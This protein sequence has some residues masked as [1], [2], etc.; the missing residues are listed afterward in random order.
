MSY[1]LSSQVRPIILCGGGGTRLWPLSRADMPKQFLP[2]VGEDSLLQA[3]AKRCQGGPFLPPAL[4]V[5]EEHGFMVVEQLEA[6]GV[7]SASILLEPA[8]RNT[9]PAVALAALWSLQLKDE[10]ILV[11]PSDHVID[12]V[13][14]LH[15]AVGAATPAALAGAIVTFGIKPTAPNPGYGY[16]RT[17]AAAQE[18]AVQEIDQFI[19]KPDP[20]LAISLLAEGN[21][22]WNSG[23]FLMQP[24]VF[25]EELQRLAPAIAYATRKSMETSEIGG[26]FVRPERS[27]FLNSP[28]DSIDYAVMEHT[29]RARV[30]PVD[31]GWSDVGTWNSVWEVLPH[32]ADGNVQHGDVVMVDVRNSLIRCESDLTVAVLGLS[33]IVCVITE[34]AAFIAPLEKAQ[35][36]RQV[37]ALLRRSD[38]ARADQPV[39]MRRPWG[40]YRTIDRGQDFQST[41]LV[42]KSGARQ[43]RQVYRGGSKRWVVVSGSAQIR[44]GEDLQVLGANESIL[45]PAG[46]P[47]SLANPGAAPLHI[48]EIRCG[49]DLEKDDVVGLED[50]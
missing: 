34:D 4:V 9:A 40:T 18:E 42:L 44:V 12:D 1:Q 39:R 49:S 16:I 27:A 15:E 11:M 7:T 5:S 32:D 14:K 25:L 45:I 2:I 20:Q 23:M 30:T 37:V 31:F 38:H 33:D 29:S 46:I 17:R 47:H 28:T 41:G 43:S 50:A 6:V 35:E 3:T 19:E 36:N 24:S 21:C 8:G 26:L 13:A 22:Y 48:I 10:L